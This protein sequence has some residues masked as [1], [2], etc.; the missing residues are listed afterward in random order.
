MTVPQEGAVPNIYN[1]IVLL[2]PLSCYGLNGEHT[3]ASIYGCQF[4]QQD[5]SD[6]V[7]IFYAYQILIHSIFILHR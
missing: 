5:V 2:F 7:E 4:L 6:V 3:L 1:N